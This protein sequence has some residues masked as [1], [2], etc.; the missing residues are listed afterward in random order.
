MEG[1]ELSEAQFKKS[2]NRLEALNFVE[3]ATGQK[4]HQLFISEYGIQAIQLITEMEEMK[5]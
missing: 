1:V 4:Q 2:L 5:C 3:I